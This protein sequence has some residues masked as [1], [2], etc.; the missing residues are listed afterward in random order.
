M[1]QVESAKWLVGSRM[2]G[3]HTEGSDYDYTAVEWDF[4]R[5]VHPLLPR[6]YSRVS[7]SENC[8]THSLPKL[9]GLLVKGN[10][11]AVDLI[12]HEPEEVDGDMIPGFIE[13]VK[14]YVI[15][16]SVAKAYLGYVNK[17][18]SLVKATGRGKQPTRQRVDG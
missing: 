8:T 4:R 3:M 7:S 10:F 15:T 13:A 5:Y 2:Y 17:Q 12:F 1:S 11:N 6:D 16:S 9:A 18:N 14:P